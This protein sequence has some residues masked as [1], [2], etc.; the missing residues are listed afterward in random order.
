MS[1]RN[2]S[3]IFSNRLSKV[4]EFHLRVH[5]IRTLTYVALATL[6]KLRVGKHLCLLLVNNGIL[7]QYIL[8]EVLT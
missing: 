3:R 1:P 7:Y 6:E 4:S 5:D 8:G 2:R